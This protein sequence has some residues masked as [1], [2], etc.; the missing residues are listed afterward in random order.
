LDK[1]G[2]VSK[3]YQ[4]AINID[5]GRKRFATKGKA[6]GG[7]ISYEDDIFEAMTAFLEAQISAG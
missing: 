5:F 6:E 3:I 2:L 4:A 1:T 7:R